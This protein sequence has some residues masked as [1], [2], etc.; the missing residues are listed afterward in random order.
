MS[1]A[2]YSAEVTAKKDGLAEQAPEE[3]I[4]PGASK[5]AKEI[6]HAIHQ[7]FEAQAL[8]SPAGV[9]VV[10]EDQALTYRELN[11][12]A[13]ALAHHLLTLGG[14]PEGVVG[15]CVERCV[16]MLVGILGILKTGAA[17]LPLDPHYP[18][19]R[20]ALMLADANVGFVVTQEHLASQ[21]LQEGT[22]IV[23]LDRDREHFEKQAVENPT[24]HVLPENAA[25][26]IYTSGSTGKPKGVVVTHGNVLRLF[27]ETQ[28]WFNFSQGDVWTLFHSY[29]FDFSVWEMWGALFHGGKVVIVPYFV[30]RNPEAFYELLC[31][32][33][34]TVLS[35][36]PSSFRQLIQADV[37][38]GRLSLR[39]V[40]FGGEALELQCLK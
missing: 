5:R 2:S 39:L 7:L 19:K 8:R 22:K 18:Q 4:G 10:F 30:S 34:V 32:E 24:V 17:Y 23:C 37:K 40:I 26:V 33:R 12:Q 6:G 13:N 14:Q 38:P 27:T 31:R 3:S 25:Y 15:L 11:E 21:L 1:R 36:T 29:A 20:L 16:E 35:Q 28:P 9:A